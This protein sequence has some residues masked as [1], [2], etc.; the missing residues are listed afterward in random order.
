MPREPAGTQSTPSA[1]APA[2][3]ERASRL[4]QQRAAPTDGGEN[5]P[6]TPS[7]DPDYCTPRVVMERTTHTNADWSPRDGSN[8]DVVSRAPSNYDRNHLQTSW[9]GRLPWLFRQNERRNTSGAGDPG[10]NFLD[11]EISRPTTS[12]SRPKMLTLK[13][14]NAPAGRS[15]TASPVISRG[16]CSTRTRCLCRPTRGNGMLCGNRM[17][18]S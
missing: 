8:P 7:R 3:C 12:E 4:S 13:P 11:A 5:H 15:R 16:T 2:R 1:P 17:N 18:K 10:C 9:E 14:H 6:L